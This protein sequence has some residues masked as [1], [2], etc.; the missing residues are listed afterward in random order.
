VGGVVFGGDLARNVRNFCYIYTTKTNNMSTVEIKS[1]VTFKELLS[2]VEQL[3]TQDLE[4]FISKLLAL[5]TQKNLKNSSKL[6]LTLVEQIKSKLPD[7]QQKRYDQLM[8]KRWE[9]TL[10]SEEHSELQ[11]M[12]DIIEEMDLKRAEAIFTLSQIKGVKPEELMKTIN[13]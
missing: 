9:E 2:G 1:K 11:K 7:P 12:I 13:I 4:K 6:E 10:T 3:S 8:Q 5:R